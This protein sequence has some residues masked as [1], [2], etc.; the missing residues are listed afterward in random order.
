MGHPICD[1]S[2]D[3]CWVLGRPGGAFALTLLFGYA[4]LRG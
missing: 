3:H 1:S 2:S 4:M